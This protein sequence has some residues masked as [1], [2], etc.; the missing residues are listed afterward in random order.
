M[1][2]GGPPWGA[3]ILLTLV[4]ARIQR[5]CRQGCMT[6]K[7]HAHISLHYFPSV[8]GTW[9]VESTAVGTQGC[10]SRDSAREY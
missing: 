1:G 6:S 7:G 2:R 3:T 5:R 4:D 9:E 10:T 8:L